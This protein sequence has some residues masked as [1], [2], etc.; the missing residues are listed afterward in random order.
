[1]TNEPRCFASSPCSD[2]PILRKDDPLDPLRSR[3]AEGQFG[4]RSNKPALPETDH[5]SPGQRRRSFVPTTSSARRVVAPARSRPHRGERDVARRPASS[6][7]PRTHRAGAFSPDC[8]RSEVARIRKPRWRRLDRCKTMLVEV[9]G[10]PRQTSSAH[11]AYD[12]QG[13]APVRQIAFRASRSRRVKL[14]RRASKRLESGGVVSLR[15][16]GR[17]HPL[18]VS[19]S[20]ECCP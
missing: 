2:G 1:V 19:H 12:W 6:S 7:R 15:R 13:P 17:N 5:R 18:A 14:R 16:R 10:R 9:A 20:I 4:R 3:K 11:P 8:G